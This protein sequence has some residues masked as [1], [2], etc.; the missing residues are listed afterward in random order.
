MVGSTEPVREVLSGETSRQHRLGRLPAG[1]GT[2]WLLDSIGNRRNGAG[3]AQILLR[4]F[5]CRGRSRKS[6]R[7]GVA[8]RSAGTVPARSVSLAMVYQK[9][10]R[11]GDLGRRRQP[12]SGCWVRPTLEPRGCSFRE[13]AHKN[14]WDAMVA[15]A[16]C[17]IFCDRSDRQLEQL[18]RRSICWRQRV[19]CKRRAGKAQA[20]RFHF[21]KAINLLGTGGLGP[22]D[23]PARV[24][25]FTLRPV[26]SNRAGNTAILPI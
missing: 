18:P 17:W 22:R 13:T 25:R 24:A 7:P 19:F 23:G 8:G 16:I 5:V 20:L 26:R 11:P 2:S 9:P 4:Q 14:S 1:R 10:V 6:E 21:Q 12:K 15:F 3:R